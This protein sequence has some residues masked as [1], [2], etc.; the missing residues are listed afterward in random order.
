MEKYKF[1]EH[2]A[3]VKFQAF[4][5]S[6]EKVFEN[7]ALALK[8]IIAEDISVR[9][10]INKKITIEEKDLESLLYNFLEE[11]LV[12]IDSENFLLGK[13][14]K[15]KILENVK[16]PNEMKYQLIAEVLGDNCKNY[17]FTNNVKAITYN[18]MFVKKERLGSK[19]QWISQIVVDV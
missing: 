11:F 1:L 18:E 3:D 8:Q 7:S 10:K 19:I 9:N 2:T 16:N 13:I 12:L 4:G 6:L 15:I 17:I 5:E 14:K